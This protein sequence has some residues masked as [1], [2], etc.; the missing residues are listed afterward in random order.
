MPTPVGHSLAGL[1]VQLAAG[2]RD[3]RRML[4]AAACLVAI[5]N[6]PDIDFLPG[7]LAGEPRAFH[8]GPTHSFAAALLVGTASGFLARRLFGGF[9]PAFTLTATAYASHVILD[10]LLGPGA[11]SQGL[12]AF[13]PFTTEPV[14]A[15]WAVFLMFPH[16]V[17]GAGPIRML[18]SSAVLPL[19]LR[20]LTIMLP[21]CAVAWIMGRA[22][23]FRAGSPRE[24]RRQPRI[25]DLTRLE[26]Q[27]T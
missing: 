20:E 10:L 8:W 19:I 22:T 14:S 7:Y 3:R 16:S 6:L 18:F 27:G 11:P 1:A 9:L 12:Q 4:L 13:W 24:G 17:D 23:R 25:P 21:V 26:E 2:E 5:A 15:P